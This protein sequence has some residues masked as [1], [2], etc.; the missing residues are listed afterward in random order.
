M[1]ASQIERRIQVLGAMSADYQ[2]LL[3]F[4]RTASADPDRATNLAALVENLERTVPDVSAA[5][6]PS[7]TSNIPDDPS[8]ATSGIVGMISQVSAL[9]RKE[10]L[11]DG[12]IER[13]DVLSKS[14]HNMRTPLT[15]PL[16]TQFSKF[17]S[18][19]GSL[20]ELQ[21]QQSRLTYLV[22]EA[23]TVSPAIAALI[24]QEALLSLYKKHLTEWRFET[25]GE[26]RTAWETLLVRMGVLGVAIAILLGIS[27]LAR[28]L[29]HRHVH[30]FDTRQMFLFGERFLFWLIIVSFV[31]FAFAFDLSSL[32]TFFGL[33]FAGVAVG[34]HDVFLAIGGHLLIVRKFHVRTGDRVQISGVAGEVIR[35]GLLDFE[36][37]EIDPATKQ[38]T[39]RVAFFSNSYVFIAPATPLF[40]QINTPAS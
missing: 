1:Q 3:R 14:L 33:L 25:Q 26:Y 12:L 37:S 2:T 18:D 6:S 8:R 22:G 15:E 16:R 31:L 24:K 36:V 40:R 7:Q 35:L 29:A 30:D 27:A 9:G 32:A 28:R 19:A 5:A 39:G 11:I 17:S 4:V 13:T 10:R 38:R 21:Q 23:K 20:D 34:L